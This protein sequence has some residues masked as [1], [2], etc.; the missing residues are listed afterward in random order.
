M[1]VFVIVGGQPTT[2]DD[3]DNTHNELADTVASIRAE[4]AK[5]VAK[6]DILEANNDRLEEKVVRLEA[7]Q[8]ANSLDNCK[9]LASLTFCYS[10]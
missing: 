9:S 6:N 10:A 3:R 7:A 4:L 5:L 8:R 1:T 2:D